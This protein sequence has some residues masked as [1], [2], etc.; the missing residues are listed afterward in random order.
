MIEVAITVNGEEKTA[1]IAADTTLLSLLRDWRLTGTK[2][3]CDEGDCGACT[4]LLDGK[5]VNGC[6]VLAG[7]ADGCSV[8][9]V[10][11]LSVD[12]RLHPL[13]EA[14][15]KHASLNAVFA[16]RAY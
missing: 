10:E 4:V 16:V 13:Q 5:S 14:F 11:G 3:G 1:A 7:R 2:L 8:T 15:E 9:T 6:L 12:G